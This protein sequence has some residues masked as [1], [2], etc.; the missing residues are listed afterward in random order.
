MKQITKDTLIQ[1]RKTQQKE[2]YGSQAQPMFVDG[3][4]N[5]DNWNGGDDIIRQYFSDYNGKVRIGTLAMDIDFT[6]NSVHFWG[7]IIITHTWY[8]DQNYVTI[9]FVGLFEKDE[10]LQLDDYDFEHV[11]FLTWYKNRGRTESVKFDGKPM[12]EEQYLF[13]LNALQETG[14]KFNLS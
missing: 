13:V 4:F 6:H 14:Y 12:T 10:K 7:D 1:L 9:T 5:P 8:D 3:V 2:F 11:A